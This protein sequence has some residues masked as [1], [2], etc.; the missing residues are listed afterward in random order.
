MIFCLQMLWTRAC[1]KLLFCK[2]LSN[3]EIN[4]KILVVAK[5]ITQS[6]NQ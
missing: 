6:T 2:E 1:L 5:N 4:A 3:T